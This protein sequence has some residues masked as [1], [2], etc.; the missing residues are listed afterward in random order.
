VRNL[1]PQVTPEALNQ[2]PAID[3]MHDALIRGR[4][5]CTFNMITDFNRESLS[6]EAGL[7]LSAQ[8]VVCVLDRLVVDRGYP[9]ML[10]MD[11]S[12]EFISLTLVEWIREECRK[13]GIYQAG[14]TNSVCFYR[15]F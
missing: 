14:Q 2:S 15:I 5:F 6:I 7:N 3:F 1:S 4:R 10:C 9:V 8:R 12:L 13:A 11:N